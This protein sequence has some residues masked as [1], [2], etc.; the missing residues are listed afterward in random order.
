MIDLLD[1]ISEIARKNCSPLLWLLTFCHKEFSIIVDVAH[2]F[3]LPSDY[4]AFKVILLLPCILRLVGYDKLGINRW[5]TLMLFTAKII[6][7]FPWLNKKNSLIL[8]WQFLH[9]LDVSKSL[10]TPINKGLLSSSKNYEFDMVCTNTVPKSFDDLLGI[11]K[12]H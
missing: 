9:P 5:I 1:F 8:W 12:N 3:Y 2:G 10:E 11:L 6:G 7:F 4:D